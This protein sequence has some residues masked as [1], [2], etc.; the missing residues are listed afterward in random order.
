[1]GKKKSEENPVCCWDFTLWDKGDNIKIS[2]I[3]DRLN[4]IAKKWC[5][6]G[7]DAGSGLHYQG[8]MSLM[9]KKRSGEF[10]FL[11]AHLSKTS[12][13]NQDNDFYVCKEETRISG[14]W[15]DTDPYVP[16]QVREVVSLYKWQKYI[17]DDINKWDTRHINVILDKGGDIGKSIC[18]SYLCTMNKNVRSIPALNSYKDIMGIVMCMPVAKLYLVDQPRAMLKSQQQEF[19]SAIESIKDGHAFDTRY[20]FK[21]KWFDCP[22]IW[23]FSN[24]PPDRTLLSHDRWRIW[25]VDESTS[26]LRRLRL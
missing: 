17:E 13:A 2:D 5:F 8:R 9:L 6:Q 15:R 11:K 7:E 4:E 23:I 16:R 24:V 21:E 19:Y 14:P 22:N 25:V 10:S 18:V 26:E 20:S 3:K 12:K 1:M